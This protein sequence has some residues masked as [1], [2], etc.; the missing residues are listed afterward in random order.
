LFAGD[1]EFDDN[2]VADG[3]CSEVELFDIGSEV[4]DFVDEV[5]GYVAFVLQIK[6][7]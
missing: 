5:V 1:S 4:T 3:D 6:V 7:F 2:F